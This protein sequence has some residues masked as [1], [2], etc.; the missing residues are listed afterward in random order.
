MTIAPLPWS[1]ICRNSCFI[2]AQTPR[3]LIRVHSVEVAGRLICGV[4]RRNH[5][6]GVVERHVEPV[7]RRDGALD[8]GGDLVFVGHVAD[9]TQRLMACGGQLVVRR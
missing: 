3:R 8:K 1:R 6:P 2:H 5:D 7:E 9:D 4:A